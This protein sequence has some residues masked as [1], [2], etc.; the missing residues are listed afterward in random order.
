MGR[1]LINTPTNDMGV[2]ELVAAAQQLA[3]S[4]KAQVHLVEG[5]ELAQ[6]F[7]LIHAVGKGAAQAPCL[8]DMSWGDVSAPKVTLVGKGVVF[9][10]GGL[11]LKPA[12]AMFLMKKDM[13]G[14][15][16]ALALAHMIMAAHLPVRLRV[17]LPIVENSVSGASF[18][19]SDIIRCRKGICVEIGDTDAEGR[20]IL[21]DALALA[22]EENPDLLVDL[23]TLTGAARVA[24]GPDLPP[25]Y[26]FDDRLA[27]ELAQA[28]FDVHDPLWR[29]PLWAPYATMLD[30]KNADTSNISSGGFA[31]SITA[32]LFLAKF[33]EKA[34]SWVHLD[35]Y[36]WTPDARPGRPVGGEIQAARALFEL[37]QRRYPRS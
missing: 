36:G 24:L 22:D 26:T 13:G 21:A 25:F 7:P 29:M 17:I 1:D 14:A 35:I 28:A 8:L 16:T 15:A 5:E 30:S 32:A 34:K 12:N 2:P 6:D 4:H 3:Q 18:R 9:D 20:L 27:Q 37:L 31:G 33:V 10:T 19:P 11:D 23:A